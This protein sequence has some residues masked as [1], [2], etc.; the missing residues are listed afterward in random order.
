[1][2]GCGGMTER[3][4]VTSEQANGA[5]VSG[6][7]ALVNNQ[8]A[9]TL[10]RAQAAAT[11]DGTI[12]GGSKWNNHYLSDEGCFR[13]DYYPRRK[14][15]RQHEDKKRDVGNVTFFY[16]SKVLWPTGLPLRG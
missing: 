3:R 16:L 1:M 14:L 5:E 6:G 4:K 9:Y 8:R 15:K 7:Q 11:R 2:D 13:S 10:C 12:R